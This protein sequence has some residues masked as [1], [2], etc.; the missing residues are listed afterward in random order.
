VAG[1]EFRSVTVEAWKG[2]QGPCYERN[3][4]VIYKGP[5]KE[6]L[7]DDNHRLFRG[8]REAVCD[9]TFNLYKKAPYREFFEF[10]EP[11]TPVPLSE[12]VPFDCSRQA[13][14]HPR[15]TKGLDYNVTSAASE[16]CGSDAG[17]CC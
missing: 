10:V 2:K 12:A 17:S 8:R 11:L 4:A 6:V 9:K 1:I 14:R 16:C 5:F 15:E 7:D 13:V 3:Q